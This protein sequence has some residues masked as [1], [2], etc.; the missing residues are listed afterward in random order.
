LHHADHDTILRIWRHHEQRR[1]DGLPTLS[2]H[3][4]TESEWGS[5]LGVFE[6]AGR[7]VV[8]SH[9]NEVGAITSDWLS[10]VGARHDVL[11]EA[12]VFVAQA[13]GVSR[14]ELRAAWA[15]RSD[16]ERL[17]WIE[18]RGAH[19]GSDLRAALETLRSA[20]DADAV[21]ALSLDTLMSWW[22]ACTHVVWCVEAAEPAGLRALLGLAAEQPTWPLL[23]SVSR[24]LWPGIRQALDGRSQAWLD[25][26][27]LPSP[28]AHEKPHSQ[29]HEEA[30]LLPPVGVRPVPAAIPPAE[31][32]PLALQTRAAEALSE[33]QRAHAGAA[34]E[35]DLLE[36]RA[37]S[38]AE[39][40][41]FE[42]L[43]TDPL[44]RGLFE[45]NRPLPF[46]FG[47]RATEPDLVSLQLRLVLEV[48]GYY[49]FQ[50]L[51]AYRRD[52]RKDVLLQQHGYLVSRHLASDVVERAGEV[53]RVI[54][55]L[56][57]QRRKNLCTENAS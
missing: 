5:T 47:A 54:R 15:A 38:L 27:M 56:V 50:E 14:G 51:D 12:F 53:L 13:L 16:S 33:S 37:R 42:L 17:R 55:E 25:S 20:L 49:H 36:Q 19:G 18:Q 3:V 30:L 1:R 29:H 34:P 24:Q 7:N 23:A 8:R 52:R 2:L 46:D 41:L 31:A 28:R 22:P 39:Q 57:T 32:A 35:R 6:G 48:D 11:D 21:S 26:S 44:T 4:G 45:L 40:R 9:A 10:A 43:S